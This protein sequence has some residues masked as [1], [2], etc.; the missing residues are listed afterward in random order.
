MPTVGTIGILV[1]RQ[2]TE[3]KVWWD[4]VYS[5][6][7]AD[8]LEQAEHQA[9]ALLAEVAV[10]GRVFQHRPFSAHSVDRLGE[11]VV[12][13]CGLE[14]NADA[15]KL[16][17]L[18]RPHARAVDDVLG[19]NVAER[20]AH[21]GHR[22]VLAQESGHRNALDDPGTLQPGTLRERHGDVDRVH[23]AVC[24]NVEAGQ[25]VVGPG[26]RP[27]LGYLARRD[28]VY[29]DTAVPVERRDAP[30]LL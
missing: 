30:V 27:Q 13:L 23:P 17:E 28:L 29:L 8:R 10:V 16:A 9:A 25:H 22:A 15:S 6:R 3:G 19:F 24:R 1:G 2:R 14:R 20:R 4:A 5:P 12:V 21:A 11:Q 26:K 18:A 7:R